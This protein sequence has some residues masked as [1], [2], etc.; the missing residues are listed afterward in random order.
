MRSLSIFLAVLIVSVGLLA[1]PASAKVTEIRYWTFLD[2]AS[3]DVRSVAQTKQI[4]RFE[5]L[6]PDIRVKVEIVHWSKQVDMYVQAT[7]AGKGP[8][9]ALVNTL[10]VPQVAAAGT[11]EPLNEFVKE[12]TEAEKQDFIIP[13]KDQFTD[14]KLWCLPLE[15]RATTV[16]YRKDLFEQ[17]GLS[18]PTSWDEVVAAARKLTKGRV[19]G[20]IFPTSHKDAAG[21][22]QFSIGLYFS[23]GGSIVDSKGRATIGNDIGIKFYQLLVDMVNKYKVMPS[24]PISIEEGRT[25][26]K[27]GVAAMYVDATQ[28]FGSLRTAQPHTS[29]FPLPSLVTAEPAPV[30]PTGQTF[31]MGINSKNKEAA[32]K[33]IKFMVGSEAQLINAKIA[34]QL[35]SL[36]SVLQDP[37]FK[38]KEGSQLLQWGNYLAKYSRGF[39]IPEHYI[40]MMDCMAKAYEQ[41]LVGGN[42]IPEALNNAA[43]QFN[44]RA[45]LE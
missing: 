40:F 36:K 41:I 14:G 42:P 45:G 12:F 27:A 11:I 26:F 2:P 25:A 15:L 19:H 44:K 7:A 4:K 5:E 1:V 8:D 3:S 29:T 28:V 30:I 37:W 9:V 39:K 34:A 18:V 38:T 6:N 31:T 35:P 21:G 13:W 23:N 22:W 20:F 16:F 10:R 33:F 43:K 24:T 32:W 17:A